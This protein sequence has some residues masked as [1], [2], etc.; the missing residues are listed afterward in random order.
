MM[1]VRMTSLSTISI[2][3]NGLFF[4][5]KVKYLYLVLVQKVLATTISSISLV[6]IRK[7][8]ETFTKICFITI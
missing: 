3:T 8:A 5:T 7:R 6:D 1:I 2:L 4:P